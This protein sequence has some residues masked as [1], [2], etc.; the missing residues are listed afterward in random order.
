[1]SEAEENSENS[2]EFS[3]LL[4]TRLSGDVM[5]STR[6]SLKTLS[7]KR[8]HLG[9]GVDTI[10]SDKFTVIESLFGVPRS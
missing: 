6:S 10:W 8:L 4:V 9:A 7:D 5:V 3:M 2:P 1:M